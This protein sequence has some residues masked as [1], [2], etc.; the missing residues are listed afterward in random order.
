[1]LRFRLKPSNVTAPCSPLALYIL[2][3]R[4]KLRHLRF[5]RCFAF[6]CTNGNRLKRLI[7]LAIGTFG[8]FERH[9]A[10]FFEKHEALFQV[11]LL[12][13][14]SRVQPRSGMSA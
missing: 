11:Y 6:G 5:R 9:F 4:V 7:N 8:F 1:M 10:D 13:L 12:H 2:D 14:P 3:S